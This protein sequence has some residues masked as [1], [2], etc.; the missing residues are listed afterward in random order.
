MSIQKELKN[1]FNDLVGELKIQ[2]IN[3]M[4]LLSGNVSAVYGALD[5]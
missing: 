3:N 2:N 1:K 4:V 5:G